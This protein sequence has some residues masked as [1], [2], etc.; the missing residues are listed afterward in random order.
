[1]ERERERPKPLKI[2]SRDLEN[3]LRVKIVAVF[4]SLKNDCK[5]MKFYKQQEQQ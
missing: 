5:Q 3:F 1:M 2:N 4:F